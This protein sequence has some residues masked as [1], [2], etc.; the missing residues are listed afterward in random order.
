MKTIKFD[1]P[2]NG[3]K[4]RNLD[5]LRHNFSTEILEL[6]ARGVLLKW[7]K[8]RHLM[9]EADK[10]S[11]IPGH[12]SDADN[13]G[14]LCE[15]FGVDAARQVI[16]A[17]VVLNNAAPSTAANPSAQCIHAP[18]ELLAPLVENGLTE[19]T[20]P[21]EAQESEQDK[22]YRELLVRRYAFYRKIGSQEPEGDKTRRELLEKR[23]ALYRE[24]GTHGPE[25]DKILREQLG[26]VPV[27][28]AE[29]VLEQVQPEV[30]VIEKELTPDE[31]LL[32]NVR[33]R[34]LNALETMDSVLKY[35]D[36]I[37]WGKTL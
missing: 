27:A 9:A 10:L 28:T 29:V 25:Q 26:I 19:K 30:V 4:V 5:E 23:F 32:A 18:T 15:I 14:A 1:L 34:I 31:R 33:R 20:A 6:H 11:A 3:S 2:I 37:Q 8:S 22:M 13:L 7:L 12:L 35:N 21:I 24:L 16:K 17:S 36:I